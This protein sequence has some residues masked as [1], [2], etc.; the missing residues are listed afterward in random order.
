MGAR[1]LASQTLAGNPCCVAGEP[2]EGGFAVGTYTL[3]NGTREGRLYFFRLAGE[4]SELLQRGLLL[5]SGLFDVRWQGAAVA[6]AASDGCVLLCAPPTDTLPA[7]VRCEVSCSTAS[8]CTSVDWAGE[9]R[10]VAC[11]QDGRAHS[12]ALSEAGAAILSSWQAHSLEA[13]VVRTS[14]ESRD[15]LF[16]GA[17]DSCF[18]GCA[19]QKAA[20]L[21]SHRVYC[22]WDMRA[23]SSQPLFNIRTTHTAGVCSVECNPHQPHEVASGAP[24]APSPAPQPHHPP[25][26]QSRKLR[27]ERVSLGRP[28]RM[29]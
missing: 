1:V 27:R 7:R 25:P 28:V 13:W 11:G 2:G 10:L 19:G 14:A 17:D 4:G 29:L 24:A 16:S 20:L 26:Q 22:S 21:A 5:A 18:K 8:M 9:E 3:D 12:I 23:L 15:V 6:C